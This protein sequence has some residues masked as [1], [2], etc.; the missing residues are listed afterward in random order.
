MA[1]KEKAAQAKAGLYAALIKAV[2]EFPDLG[3]DKSGNYGN[4]GSLPATLKAVRGP[5]AEHG[6][7]LTQPVVWVPE[8]IDRTT[9]DTRPG[10]AYLRTVLTHS[11]SGEQLLSELPLNVAQDEKRIGSSMTYFRRYLICSLLG[12]Q[13]DD[14]DLDSEGMADEGQLEELRRISTAMASDAFGKKHPDLEALAGAIRKAAAIQSGIKGAP[15]EDQLIGFA[16]ALGAVTLA[17][18]EEG[19]PVIAAE[20]QRS[21]GADPLLQAICDGELD[22]ADMPISPTK[23]A[24]KQKSARLKK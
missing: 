16:S 11:A 5:L 18:D 20:P 24:K 4:Y 9:G 14:I 3:K 8:S 6:L 19:N 22:P 13:A 15:R 2:Q 17:T 21:R 1:A 12:I 10:Q 7:I 23:Q